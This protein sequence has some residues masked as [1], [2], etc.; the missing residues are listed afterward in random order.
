M[1]AYMIA[2]SLTRRNTIMDDN[3]Y[4]KIIIFTVVCVVTMSL[5]FAVRMLVV[6]NGG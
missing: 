1:F 5:L 3:R 6:S 4:I 2:C